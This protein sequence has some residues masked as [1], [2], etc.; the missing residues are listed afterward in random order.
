MTEKGMYVSERGGRSQP[1]S[2]S[3][4]TQALQQGINDGVLI[5]VTPRISYNPEEERGAQLAVTCEPYRYRSGQG[6][7]GL[8][9]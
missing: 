2:Y 5:H 6:R 9:R 8:L 4:W 7:D 1:N 3:I